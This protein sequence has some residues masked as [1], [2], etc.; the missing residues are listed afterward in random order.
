MPGT[1]PHQHPNA[2]T[3]SMQAEQLEFDV[4]AAPGTAPTAAAPAPGQLRQPREPVRYACLRATPC[5][6]LHPAEGRRDT[7]VVQLRVCRGARGRG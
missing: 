1:L 6:S 7:A 2:T 4:E 5:S 3:R